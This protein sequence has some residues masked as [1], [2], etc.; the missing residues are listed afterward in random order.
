MKID[1]MSGFSERRHLP[2]QFKDPGGEDPRRGVCRSRETPLSR[3]GALNRLDHH[4]Q[5]ERHLHLVERVPGAQIP[6]RSPD[7]V[8]NGRD[9]PGAC[10][11]VPQIG[12]Q[13]GGATKNHQ[14]FVHRVVV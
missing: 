12:L 9:L 5:L 14:F 1:K 8:Q 2:G 4:G 6:R 3:V 10:R 11:L 13:I 7:L